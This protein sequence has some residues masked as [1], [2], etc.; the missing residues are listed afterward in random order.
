MK[1]YDSYKE[2]GVEWIG[3]IPSHWYQKRMSY[4]F[5]PISIKNNSDEINLSVYRDYGVIPTNSRDDNHNVISEDT[6]NY[7]LVEVGDFVMNKMKC[8]MGSLGL[9]DFR[10]IVSPSYTVMKPLTKNNRKYFHYLLRS[11]V[12][13][14]Q[15][16]RLSYGVRIGQWDLHF[17]DFRELPCLIPP[18]EEQ[19]QIVEHIDKQTQKID[20]LVTKVKKKIKLLKEQRISLINE[21]VTKGLNPDVE[22]KDSGVEW[23]GETPKHWTLSKVK[24]VSTIKRGSSPRPIDDPRYFDEEG[25][26]G[27]VRISDVT[28]CGKYLTKTDQKLSELG[29][30]L[31]LPIEDKTLCMSI[32]GSV[33]K[34][35]IT[36]IK[37]CIHDGFVSLNNPQI[38]QE[39]FYLLLSNKELYSEDRKL[40]TQYNINSGLVG[41]KK[42]PIPSKVE[43]RE[44]VEYLERETKIIDNSIS[45]EEKRVELLKEYKQSLISEVVTGKKRVTEDMI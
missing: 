44:I 4:M 1:R 10:G 23:I 2:S 36:T 25:D 15:Y 37:C 30:S 7:K 18:I 27:W 6:S 13:I 5:R 41:N 11:K 22:M 45:K 31:S 26:Y 14:P 16:R 29:K 17:E 19:Q 35:F 42:I 12:Y 38:N 32:S 39:F 43:Q 28:K 21:V 24:Y 34:V 20:E 33:G 9:S 3:E 40:G 8:W